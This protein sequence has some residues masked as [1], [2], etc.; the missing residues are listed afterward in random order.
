MTPTPAAYLDLPPMPQASFA[1]NFLPDA[2][3]VPADQLR[4]YAAEAVSQRCAKL[5][6]F[7]REVAQLTI[8][9][10]VLSTDGDDHAVVY[11]RKLGKALEKVCADWCGAAAIRAG[12]E[13]K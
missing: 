12:G 3:V 10:D 7:F 8:E 2:V 1:R 5:E 9:H 13:T 6:A 4:A 11:P